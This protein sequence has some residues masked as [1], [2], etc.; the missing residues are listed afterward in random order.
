MRSK[1]E[2]FI[3]YLASRWQESDLCRSPFIGCT[4]AEIA[5]I[6]V[7]QGVDRLPIL[8]V[9]WMLRMGRDMG[10]LEWHIGTKLCYPYVLEFKAQTFGLLQKPDVLVLS[11]D[12]DGDCALYCHTT[13]DDPLI[14]WIGYADE[15]GEKLNKFSVQEWGRLSNWLTDLVEGAIGVYADSD[16]AVE[17][18][19]L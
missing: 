6:Q 3:S 7:R 19:N 14:F 17:V 11:H 1:H 5:K 4:E 8:Y 10:G 2:A 9:A 15:P 18:E 13:E 16:D 12:V